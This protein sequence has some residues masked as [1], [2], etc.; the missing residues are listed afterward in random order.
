MAF[1]HSQ[2]GGCLACLGGLLGDY[3]DFHLQ[4]TSSNLVQGRDNKG[5]M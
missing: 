3:G 4:V 2:Q 1:Q 5:I